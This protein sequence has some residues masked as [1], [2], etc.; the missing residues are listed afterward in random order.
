MKKYFLIVLLFFISTNLYS[1]EIGAL[2]VL[3]GVF[4]GGSKPVKNDNNYLSSNIDENVDILINILK[5]PEQLSKLI[6]ALENIKSNN[7]SQITNNLVNNI[8]KQETTIINEVYKNLKAI[9]N[10]ILLGIQEFLLNI[11]DILHTLWLKLLIW[12]TWLGVSVVFYFLLE[13]IFSKIFHNDKGQ[14]LSKI[15]INKSS[16]KQNILALCVNIVK[17]FIPV[18]LSTIIT[19]LLINHFINK[20]VIIHYYNQIIEIL[21]LLFFLRIFLYFFTM[22]FYKLKKRTF[23]KLE[24]LIHWFFYSILIFFIFNNLFLQVYK[25]N[26]S[27]FL[28]K[29][30]LITFILVLLYIFFKMK[31]LIVKII[32]RGFFQDK[33]EGKKNISYKYFILLLK[34]HYFLLA[35]LWISSIL[36]FV[37]FLDYTLAKALLIKVFVSMLSVVFIY[38][39]Y[40]I[41]H[42][43]LY[44]YIII[45]DKGILQHLKDHSEEFL[46]AYESLSIKKLGQF[47]NFLYKIIFYFITAYVI[48][49]IWSI[50]IN[51]TLLIIYKILIIKILFNIFTA[52]VLILLCSLIIIVFLQKIIFKNLKNNDFNKVKKIL[53]VFL[54]CKKPYYIMVSLLYLIII[55]IF[56]GVPLSALLASTGVVTVVFAFASK[57][58]LQ[59]FFNAMLFLI[60]DSF[61]LNDM[62][63]I[64]DKKGIVESMSL[65]YVKLRDSDGTLN[66]IPFSTISVI[67]NYSKDYSFSIIDI[68]ISYKCDVDNIYYL[69][70]ESYKELLLNKGISIFVLEK[71]DIVGVTSVSDFSMNIRSKIK[72]IGGKQFTVRNAFL[73]IA[74]QKFK[75]N[76][77]ELPSVSGVII[78]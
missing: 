71:I 8:E 39:T 14:A 42:N 17:L 30:N 57:D 47:F 21:I 22:I 54:L 15:K 7:D 34:K 41:I 37:I 36:F 65:I 61:A 6:I 16:V 68:P 45:T 9:K 32:S 11:Y 64:G 77:I 1:A 33:V 58:I 72:T 18:I 35:G 67:T 3:S 56:F 50:G 51:S 75:D 4:G 43:L 12:F 46:L 69:L 29:L 53:S 63:A 23:K 26:N 73:K 28:L 2:G 60:E 49:S 44:N 20:F 52:L 59:N 76:N 74:Y 5:N 24:S 62:I 38:L 48:D 19:I 40:K 10:N 27:S 31:V 78:N 70:A 25:F 55:L 13:K 66:L